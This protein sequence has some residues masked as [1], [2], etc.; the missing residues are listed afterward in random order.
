MLPPSRTTRRPRNFGG[1]IFHLSF[2][3]ERGVCG[4]IF[5]PVV[6]FCPGVEVPVGNGSLAFWIAHKNRTEISNPSSICGDMKKSTAERFAPAFFRMPRTARSISALSDS[7]FARARPA[8]DG[9]HNVCV[10]PR[11]GREF[12]GPIRFPHGATQSQGRAA[13]W[14]FQ[15]RGHPESRSRSGTGSTWSPRVRATRKISRAR[16]S[17]RAIAPE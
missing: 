4:I 2:G 14:A 10:N 15:F 11:N 9:A 12:P 1:D 6:V 17:L 8:K 7:G 16:A 3:S 5:L 13:E